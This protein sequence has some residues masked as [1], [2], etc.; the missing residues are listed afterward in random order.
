[1]LYTSEQIKNFNI[2]QSREALGRYLHKF[3]HPNEFRR[4][5]FHEKDYL[6]KWMKAIKDDNGHLVYNLYKIPEAAEFVFFYIILTYGED[7]DNF[8]RAFYG[9]RGKLDA[10]TV[11]KDQRFFNEYLQVWKNQVQKGKGPYFVVIKPLLNRKLKELKNNC[12]TEQEYKGREKYCYAVFFWIYYRARLYFEEKNQKFLT[13]NVLG[14]TFVANI[15][16]YFHVFSR[17]YVPSL[18]V[19]LGNT[20]NS[21]IP[22]IDINNFLESIK[23]LVLKYFDKNPYI[24]TNKEFLLYKI[25]NENYILWIQF[26][27]LNELSHKEGFEIRSFYKCEKENDIK[28]FQDTRE[29]IFDNDCYCC[30]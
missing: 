3:V 11:R 4:I 6:F 9:P 22:C 7:V 15:Y 2:Y 27:K 17:H 1:M 16:S 19:G 18:N 29:V 30:I 8:S 21:D 25:K 5:K 26:K 13:F 14:Y 20:M 10:N 24:D 28:R 12:K 23:R